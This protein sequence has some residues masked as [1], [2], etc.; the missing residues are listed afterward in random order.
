MGA[1]MYVLSIGQAHDILSLLPKFDINKCKM[2]SHSS[3]NI[4]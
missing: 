4:V 2:V 3:F 1:K